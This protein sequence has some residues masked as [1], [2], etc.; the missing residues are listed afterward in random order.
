MKRTLHRSVASAVLWLLS[1]FFVIG[2]NASDGPSDD[3]D[4]MFVEV[5]GV[6]QSMPAS[7]LIGNWTIGGR[8]VQTD[9]AT[10]FDQEDSSIGVGALVE[11]KGTKQGDGSVLAIKVEVHSGAGPGTGDDE[12][13]D[14]NGGESDDGEVQGAIVSL[15][16]SGLLGTWNVAGRTVIVV[17]TTRLDQE[18]GAMVIGAIV[19]VNGLADS[20]G[21]IVASKIEVKSGTVGGSVPV[22]GKVELV[23]LIEALPATGLVGN[24]QVGGRTVVVTDTTVL[25]PEHG[26]FAVG[27]SVEAKGALDLAGNLLAAKIETTEG[28][29][30]PVP[31]LEF[32]GTVV[33]LP[34]VSAGFVGVW[35]VDDKLVNVTP[36]TEIEVEDAPLAVGV[37]VEVHGWIQPDGIVEAKEI[38]TR[39]VVGFVAGQGTKAVE[40]FNGTLGHFFVSANPAEIAALDAGGVWQRTGQAFNVGSG[41]RGV[42]RFYG[43]PPK[44]PDSHFFTADAAECQAVMTQFPAW[45]FEGHAFSATPPVNGQCPAGKLEV[46]R[47]FNN[48]T[49]AGEI[50]HRFTVT[51]QALQQTLAL[52]WTHE[53]VVMCAHP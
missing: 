35:K 1:A 33:E 9:S 40:F 21:A 39:T 53:G 2:A 38:E 48:P 5:E 49:T 10:R 25:D 34:A 41:S 27:A 4:A 18:H 15:P 32:W 31:A 28:N 36:A 14:D 45:T 3:S 20:T 30:A 26:G 37:T 51:P 52:G 16:A 11:V 29:G 50:N 12:E 13:D 44:G 6:V 7:G 23:G 47:F 46:H 22:P 24:W 42:C 19:E 43:M 17:S 8:S